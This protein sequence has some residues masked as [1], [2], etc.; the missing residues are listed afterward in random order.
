MRN[1][2]PQGEIENENEIEKR[3][4]ANRIKRKEQRGDARNEILMRKDAR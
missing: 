2:K 3:K 4:L 1:L